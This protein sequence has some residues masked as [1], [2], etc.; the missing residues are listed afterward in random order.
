MTDKQNRVTEPLELNGCELEN[1]YVIGEQL[2]S[3][4]NKEKHYFT[5]ENIEYN[6]D[7]AKGGVEMIT[8]GV[9]SVNTGTGVDSDR[10]A[11]TGVTDSLQYIA[12]AGEMIDSIHEYG[13]KVFVPLTAIDTFN[14]EEMNELSQQSVEEEMENITEAF[15]RSALIAKLIGYDGVQINAV[16]EG[17]LLNQFSKAF[18]WLAGNSSEIDLEAHLKFATDIVGGIKKVC[19]SDFPVTLRFRVGSFVNTLKKQTDWRSTVDVELNEMPGAIDTIKILAIAGYDALDID[20][21]AGNSW[22]LTNEPSLAENE[23]FLQEINYNTDGTEVPL[24]GYSM[25]ENIEL[26]AKVLDKGIYDAINMEQFLC[27]NQEAM[28]QSS[29]GR[30]HKMNPGML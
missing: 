1:R 12:E 4:Q 10:A 16:H 5:K 14:T 6:I 23:G 18:Y 24:F 3:E 7:R 26:A 9:H 17:Y 15:V 13:A 22:C 2:N 27:Y 21:G 25:I 28:N 20:A 30:Y 29:M 19:G 11:F 8:V